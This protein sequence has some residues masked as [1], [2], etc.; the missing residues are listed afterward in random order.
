MEPCP[1]GGFP[2]ARLAGLFHAGTGLLM[3]LFVAPLCT[4]ELTHV[5]QV[6]PTLEPGD[7]LVADRGLGSYAHLA[8]LVQAGLHA[9]RRVGARQ[10]VDCT[11]GRPI[12]RP[13]SRRTPAI[14]GL[15]RSQWLTALGHHDQAGSRVSL[16]M[17]TRLWPVV[18]ASW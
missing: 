15:P 5:P 9:V 7:E 12:V 16:I 13:D 17:L 6:H 1:G 10:M 3:N 2:V 18:S 11:L 14:Q 4:R 8:L